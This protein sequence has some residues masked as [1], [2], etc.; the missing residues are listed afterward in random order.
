MMSFLNREKE[1]LRKEME[2]GGV[3]SIV[4][5]T[6]PNKMA[7][8]V[9][10]DCRAIRN[11]APANATIPNGTRLDC[12]HLTELRYDG[13]SEL[14]GLANEIQSWLTDLACF[15][16]MAT[17]PFRIEYLKRLHELLGP[18]DLAAEAHYKR[19]VGEE[20]M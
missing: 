11:M 5:W 20:E 9:E 12:H 16:P 3:H 15:D 7:C 2:A 6:T 10:V 18:A 4:L 14:I 13:V 17:D 1:R 19:A 8:T